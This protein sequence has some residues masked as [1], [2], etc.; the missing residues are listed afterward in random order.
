MANFNLYFKPIEEKLEGTQ[1]ED[2]AGDN[3]HGTRYGLIADDLH[4]YQLHNTLNITS[5]KDLTEEQA[6]AM[7]KALYWDYFKADYIVNQ[8]LAEYIVD[9]GLNCGRILIAKYVQS[10]LNLTTDGLIG[11]VTLHQINNSN[12]QDLFNKL[13]DKREA[14]YAAIIAG[15]PSQIKFKLGWENR[16]NAIKFKE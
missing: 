9:G 12:Q 1:Y 2:V 5:V 13:H 4:E 6:G 8:S 11:S 16:N 14:R 7:L 10:I 3:G 15:N